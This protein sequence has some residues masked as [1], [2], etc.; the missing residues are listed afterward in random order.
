MWQK[1]V[2]LVEMVYKA[3][4]SFPR[5]EDH[6]SKSQMRRAAVSIPSNIAE[7]SGRGTTKDYVSFLRIARGSVRELETHVEIA[8]KGRLYECRCSSGSSGASSFRQPAA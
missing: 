8:I 5:C 6:A 2:G 3:T 1:G 7:G 4:D